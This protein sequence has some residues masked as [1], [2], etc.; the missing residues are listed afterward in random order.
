MRSRSWRAKMRAALLGPGSSGR[1]AALR[2][3]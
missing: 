2:P 1:S 3:G